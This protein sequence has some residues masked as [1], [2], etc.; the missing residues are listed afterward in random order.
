MRRMRGVVAVLAL[1]A[2]SVATAAPAA[3]ETYELDPTYPITRVGHP[4]R[5]DFVEDLAI[6]PDGRAV[7][8][9][10]GNDDLQIDRFLASGGLDPSWGSGGVVVLEGGTAGAANALALQPDGKVVVVG[11]VDTNTDPGLLVARLLPD[12]RLDPDFG[13][14]GE[15]L[16]RTDTYFGDLSAVAIGPGGS[17]VAAGDI[18]SGQQDVVVLRLTPDGDLDP[19]FGDEG[20]AVVTTPRF[21]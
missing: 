7:V 18:G 13:F 1:V 8:A 3:A 12:G 15:V 9:G 2:V 16:I 10:W 14:D 5:W 17:I 20:I 11:G 6:Q 19:T 21:E 4:D